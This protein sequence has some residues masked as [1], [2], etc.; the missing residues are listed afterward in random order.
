MEKKT[1][2]ILGATGSIGTQSVDVI[3]KLKNFKIVGISFGKNWKLAEDIIKKFNIK[4]YHGSVELS[5]GKG[6]N[7]ISE[8]LEKTLP[9]IVISAI[10][11]FDG[12][13]A[14]I[15]AIK[16][17]KRIALAT[18]EAMV[19]AGPFV[20]SI[21][22]ERNVEIIPVDSEH[23]AIF[24]LYEPYIDHI[25]ITASGGAVRD[26]PLEKIPYLKPTDVLK[27]PTWSMGNRI[28]VDSATM[29]NKFF[30][31]VEAHELFELTYDKIEVFINPS[32]FVHGIVF[33]KDGTIKIHAGKPD[34]RVPIAYSLT[35]PSREYLSYVSRV[36]EFDMRLLTVEKS[37]YPL[38]FFGL[39][40]I[41]NGG[42]AE[43]IAFNSAD[44]LAVQY[45]LENHIEFGKIERIVKTTVEIINKRDFKINSLED[46]YEADKL[47]RQI[48]KEVLYGSVS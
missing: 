39:E 13:R 41:K 37:R 36:E 26:I 42:L 38:F 3:S 33:L 44:E 43:R 19:C 2:V 24:Q 15:E 5:V 20:K 11:G 10:P 34:M 18:K 23:S 48:A 7:T 30:E 45:F 46:I 29:V 17:T 47:A 32:S 40:I 16:Y 27:H 6:L 1:V 21:A 35:Y 28:T 22:K 25:V 31:V 4:F 12:V 14:T 8:L 9:D